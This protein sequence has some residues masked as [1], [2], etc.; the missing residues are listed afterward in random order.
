MAPVGGEL[1]ERDKV[2]LDD[3]KR[4]VDKRNLMTCPF[5]EEDFTSQEMAEY[6]VQLKVREE[7]DKTQEGK[8]VRR[9]EYMELV[10]GR[11]IA[12][13]VLTG[14]LCV[15]LWKRIEAPGNYWIFFALTMLATVS[16]FSAIIC[17]ALCRQKEK[18]LFAEFKAKNQSLSSGS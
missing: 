13:S 14:F 11:T 5:C 18:K 2:E 16:F 1:T 7:F 8:H 4:K 15:L 6:K 9:L 10:F 17:L 12:F 3:F